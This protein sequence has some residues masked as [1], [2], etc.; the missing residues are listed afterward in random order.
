MKYLPLTQVE[1]IIVM[2]ALAL[3]DAY[4]HGHIKIAPLRIEAG[5][6]TDEVS[7]SSEIIFLLEESLTRL[8]IEIRG[9]CTHI[10]KLTQK[11]IDYANLP[12]VPEF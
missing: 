2:Q 6:N 3:Y 8:N 1:E 10:H 12:P 11:L 7:A 9:D 4:Y 5:A